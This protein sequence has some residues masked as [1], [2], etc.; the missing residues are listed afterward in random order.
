MRERDRQL[1]DSP[2]LIKQARRLRDTPPEPTAPSAKRRSKGGGRRRKLT[3][4]EIERL[5][6]AHQ[7][8]YR[9]NPKRKQ[10]DVFADL[11][12]L[13]GR[14]VGDATLRKRVVRPLSPK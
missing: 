1:R 11:C 14:K 7:A 12:T 9:D 4:D 8:A 5:Q 13:L 6:A 3:P 2:L 10:A